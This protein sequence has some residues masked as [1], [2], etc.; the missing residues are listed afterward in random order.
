MKNKLWI[1][2]IRQL[3][4]DQMGELHNALETL[5]QWSVFKKEYHWTRLF[6]L[7]YFMEQEMKLDR[8]E[9]F[10]NRELSCEELKQAHE[11]MVPVRQRYN[12]EAFFDFISSTL[13]SYELDDIA[14]RL[15]DLR[16]EYESRKHE[17]NL[18]YVDDSPE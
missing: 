16:R 8:K 11:D 7:K 17:V 1:Q 6:D 3:G 10:L 5:E 4:M 15:V 9:E 2:A 12:L 13:I 14:D 18:F